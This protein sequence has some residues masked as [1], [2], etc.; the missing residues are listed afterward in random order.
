M[1]TVSMFIYSIIAYFVAFA[2]ALLAVYGNDL[3]W[4]LFGAQATIMALFSVYL[5]YVQWALVGAFCQFCLLSALTSISLFAVFLL[6]L[7]V[8]RPP[9][10]DLE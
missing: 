8:R 5:I 4:K 2:L 10:E 7:A 6:S 9:G 3:A 1:K